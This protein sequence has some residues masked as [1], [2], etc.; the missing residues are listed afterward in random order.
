MDEPG[1][2]AY[3]QI[4]TVSSG[5]LYIIGKGQVDEFM[6]V[7]EAAVEARKV[8]ILQQDT[9]SEQA[10]IYSFPVDSHLSQ[11]TVQV[12]NHKRGQAIDVRIRNPQSK[13]RIICS[14]LAFQLVYVLDV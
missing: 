2:E 12:A 6:Q 9:Y 5:Q 10:K 4:A 7:V 1:F 8:H 13:S 14:P 3:R 11:L